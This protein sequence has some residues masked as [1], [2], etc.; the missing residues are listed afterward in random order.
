LHELAPLPWRTDLRIEPGIVFDAAGK[1]LLA[2][3]PW[4]D[5]PDRTAHAIA[6][7]IVNAVNASAENKER[8]T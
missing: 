6:E 3:D 5:L 1:P 7:A 4:N 2:I 8:L